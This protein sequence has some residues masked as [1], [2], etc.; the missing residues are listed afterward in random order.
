MPLN[1]NAQSSLDAE[2]ITL[3]E[4]EEI[5]LVQVCN[6]QIRLGCPN[7]TPS[8]LSLPPASAPPLIFHLLLLFLVIIL[9]LILTSLC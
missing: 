3:V 6:A 5:E 8:A 9:L 7:F 1:D 4:L 2:W